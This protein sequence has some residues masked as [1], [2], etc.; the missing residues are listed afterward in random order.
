MDIYLNK[1]NKYLLLVALLAAPLIVIVLGALYF[2]GWQGPAD[3]DPTAN[4]IGYIVGVLY[5]VYA[6]LTV[7]CFI[8]A[9]FLK[10]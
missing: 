2:Y 10:K 6:M 4:K 5:G 3:N 8:Y 7:I 1:M 9:N